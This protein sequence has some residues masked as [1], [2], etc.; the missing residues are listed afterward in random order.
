M[1]CELPFPSP[2]DL[3]DPG[4]E[5]ASLTSPALAGGFFTP[6]ATWEAPPPPPHT[7]P[8]PLYES[9]L[10]PCWAGTFT[11]STMVANPKLQ[12]FADR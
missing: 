7:L 11:W 12:F 1:G 2:G 9:I 8:F 4:M 5:P 3:P 6:S 10:F